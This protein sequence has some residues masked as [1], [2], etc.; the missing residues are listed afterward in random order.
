MR[1]TF[2]PQRHRHT[3]KTLKNTKFGIVINKGKTS[4]EKKKKCP[5]NALWTTNKQRI[6]TNTIE[7]FYVDHLLLGMRPAL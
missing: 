4:Q 6:S 5:E 7:L 3:W 1:S 2:T